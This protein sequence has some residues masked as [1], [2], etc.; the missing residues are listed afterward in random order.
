MA[1]QEIVSRADIE[2]ARQAIQAAVA[3]GRIAA[4]EGADRSEKVLHAVTPRDLYGASGGLA[5][6]PRATEAAR[7]ERRSITY[8]IIAMIVF[9]I[10]VMAVVTYYVGKRYG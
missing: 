1:D 4:Q 8:V 7:A 9:A 2:A 5:G 10:V 3:D 6:S